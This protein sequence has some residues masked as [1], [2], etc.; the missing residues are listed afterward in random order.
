MARYKAEIACGIVLIVFFTPL[1]GML[2]RCGCT[3]LWSGAFSGCNIHQANTPHCPWCAAPL[4]LQS[5]TF[6]LLC[7]AGFAGIR[8]ARGN[9]DVHFLRDFTV[10]WVSVLV[11]AIVT[12]WV[13]KV[14]MNYP[15]FLIW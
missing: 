7:I 14:T 12:A 1:C 13:Y 6:L 2:F 8:L 11:V 15:H 5:L 4:L 9:R 3:F 10:G